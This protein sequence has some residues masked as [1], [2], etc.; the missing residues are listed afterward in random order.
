MPAGADPARDAMLG[1]FADH[2][3]SPYLT[4]ARA[5]AEIAATGARV[6]F[7]DLAPFSDVAPS[8]GADVTPGTDRRCEVAFDGDRGAA[9]AET[10]AAALEAEGIRADAPVPASHPALP[11]TTLLGARALNPS[12]VA[13]VHTGTRPGPDGVETF[14]SVERLTPEASE[15]VLR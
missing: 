9:A 7:Y 5:E 2:C 8:P 13:V 11:G 10:A 12:R 15:E 6:D 1:A 3:F 14:L 4:A